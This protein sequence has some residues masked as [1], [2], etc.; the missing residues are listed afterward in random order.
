M[1]QSQQWQFYELKSIPNSLS[2]NELCLIIVLWCLIQFFGNILLLG[3]I[4]FERLAGD[5]L[6]REK[7]SLL[8]IFKIKIS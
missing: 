4:Q 5:P 6:K 2:I 7:L 1:N 3:L 8:P